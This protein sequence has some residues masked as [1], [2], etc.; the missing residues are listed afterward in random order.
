MKEENRD[1]DHKL[2]LKS[3]QLLH[4]IYAANEFANL[5]D[6][7]D[8][9]ILE[10][11][12]LAAISSNPVRS[13]RTV[14]NKNDQRELNYVKNVIIDEIQKGNSY[15]PLEKSRTEENEIESVNLDANSCD[16]SVIT[17]T[18]TGSKKRG[19]PVGSGSKSTRS[20]RTKRVET[21]KEISSTLPTV[22]EQD[23]MDEVKENEKNDTDNKEP[24]GKELRG[25]RSRR[26]NSASSISTS[27]EPESN[28][29]K[30]RR[31]KTN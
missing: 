1:L 23:Q 22:K 20:K 30:G 19:R 25:T 26:S 6:V 9:D 15:T 24:L 21:K 7:K 2:L 29:I 17:S 4:L 8:D 16:E 13:G 31:K 14:N 18:S 5:L 12:L 28:G 3:K 27:I 11:D 10:T